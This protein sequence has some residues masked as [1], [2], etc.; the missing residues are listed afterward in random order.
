MTTN[1][2]A[3]MATNE[4]VGKVLIDQVHSCEF[5]ASKFAIAVAIKP[6]ICE[7]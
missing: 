3:R 7:N 1:K 6:Y 2:K 4:F 5:Q